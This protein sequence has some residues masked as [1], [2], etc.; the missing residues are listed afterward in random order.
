MNIINNLNKTALYLISNSYSVTRYDKK[1]IN[2]YGMVVVD[3]TL[4]FNVIGN[5]QPYNHLYNENKVNKT[6]FGDIDEYHKVFYYI[7]G[8]YTL[9]NN[10]SIYYNG[11]NW[12]VVAQL[13]FNQYG[14]LSYICKLEG[15][16]SEQNY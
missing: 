9:R 16:N 14:N 2:D 10:D 12:I 5:F 8:D 7:S 3:N 1:S 11:E 4:I 15:A 6:N 13:D